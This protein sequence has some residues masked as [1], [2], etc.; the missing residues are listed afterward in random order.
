MTI[1]LSRH[2]AYFAH[3][4]KLHVLEQPVDVYASYASMTTSRCFALS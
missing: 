4:D 3:A 1:G 2:A